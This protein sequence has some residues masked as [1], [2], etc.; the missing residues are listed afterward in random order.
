MQENR[1]L[2]ELNEYPT[3]AE[4][5]LAIRYLDPDSCTGMTGRDVGTVAGTCI[6][7]FTGLVTALTYIGCYVWRL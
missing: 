6:P 3:D 1:E 7:L 2:R 5:I 4:I